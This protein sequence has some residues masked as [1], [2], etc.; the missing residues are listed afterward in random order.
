[1]VAAYI[2]DVLNVSFL[3]L[4]KAINSFCD[5]LHSFACREFRIS[6]DV[7]SKFAGK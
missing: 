6:G 3:P 7:N 2:H 4:V 1:M 5:E